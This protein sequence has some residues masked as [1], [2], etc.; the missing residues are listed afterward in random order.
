VQLIAEGV[1]GG[2]REG[3]LRLLGPACAATTK[4]LIL[5]LLA[6]HGWRVTIDL[7]AA[8]S[9]AFVAR[10]ASWTD[11]PNSE[12]VDAFGLGSWNQSLC[13]CGQVHRETVIIFRPG[14]VL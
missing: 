8:Q 4:G 13:P 10:F 11:E 6:T 1:D 2:S 12:Q 7:F 14:A 5:E 9:N 3:A